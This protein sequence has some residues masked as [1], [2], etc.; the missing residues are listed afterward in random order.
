[1]MWP[2]GLD[3]FCCSRWSRW[4]ST[5]QNGDTNRLSPARH[6]GTASSASM[7]TLSGRDPLNGRHEQKA[8]K[9]LRAKEGAA[10]ERYRHRRPS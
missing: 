2:G 4:R 10:Q 9:A 5:Q 8:M 3:L 6:H 1:M 7:A